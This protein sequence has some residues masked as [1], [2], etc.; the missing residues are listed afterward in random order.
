MYVHWD[1]YRYN[2]MELNGLWWFSKTIVQLIGNQTLLFASLCS[3]HMVCTLCF[4][5]I[6]CVKCLYL[7]HKTI[8]HTH[9]HKFSFMHSKKNWNNILFYISARTHLYK[10]LDVCIAINGNLTHREIDERYYLWYICMAIHLR[11]SP[12][13]FHFINMHIFMFVDWKFPAGDLQWN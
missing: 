2:G 3:T 12:D 6:W 11:N 4:M 8:T 7:A 10:L 5:C 13:T 1:I 9:T